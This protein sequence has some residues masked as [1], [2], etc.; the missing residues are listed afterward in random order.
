MWR[1]NSAVRP[2]PT[3]TARR[4]SRESVV[5]E[6]PREALRSIPPLAR[7]LSSA[8]LNRVGRTGWR[9]NWHYGRRRRPLA[10]NVGLTVAAG[11][12]NG[13]NTVPHFVLNRDVEGTR[14]PYGACALRSRR[15]AQ[16]DPMLAAG[17]PS[18]KQSQP[19][20]TAGPK[21]LAPNHRRLNARNTID[22]R[23]ATLATS[24]PPHHATTTSFTYWF[25][26]PFFPIPH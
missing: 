6:R 10:S 20:S 22:H 5:H 19:P 17:E 8:K 25:K 13:R 18:A 23:H 9:S 4:I 21:A 14:G 26:T 16:R 11:R 7:S 15:G 1:V 12:A 24:S 2:A 3:A